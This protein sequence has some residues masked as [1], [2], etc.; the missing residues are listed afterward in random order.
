MEDITLR[1]IRLLKEA[2][3]ILCEDTRT[4]GILLKHFNI[5][6][7]RLMSHHKFNEHSTSQ[8]IVERLKGGANICLITDA[9]TPGI[10]DPGFYLVREAIGAGIEVQTLPG[11]TAFVPALVSSGLPCDRFCFEGFLPQKKGR[12]ARM[13]ELAIEPRTM[14]IYESPRRIVKTLEQ[15]CEVLG[16]DR[17]MSACREISKIHEESIRGTIKEVAE[18]FRQ[19]EPKGEFVLIVEGNNDPVP[20]NTKNSDSIEENQP[21]RPLSKYQRKLAQLSNS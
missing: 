2:D 8:S 19:N 13:Q 4:S 21:E 10:S 5:T 9:G 1:A 18:Y 20:S 12:Q 17:H 14:I 16:A 11:A 6:E 7:K 3:L 15:L